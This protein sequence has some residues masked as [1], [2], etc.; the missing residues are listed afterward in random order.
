MYDVLLIKEVADGNL[1]EGL[2]DAILH[3]ETK[4]PLDFSHFFKMIISSPLR[5][6]GY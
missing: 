6:S 4:Q 2:L 3:A 5:K 1:G